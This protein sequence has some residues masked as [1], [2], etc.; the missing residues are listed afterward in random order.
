N[1]VAFVSDSVMAG[2]KTGVAFYLSASQL[3]KLLGFKGGSGDFWERSYYILT[4][5]SQTHLPSLALG[6]SALVLL[7][8]GKVYLP[9]RPVSVRV[10]AASIAAVPLLGLA[11]LGVKTLGDVPRGI[12]APGLPAVHGS[13]LNEL[14]PLAIACF[15]V[16]AV[17]TT[18]IGRMFGRKH[19]YRL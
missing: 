10:V 19:R 18:A 4:H 13:D 12:P 3:P 1:L 2:F 6:L 5:L 9:S 14:L 11:D 16:G 17:E 8:A 15:L 7:L